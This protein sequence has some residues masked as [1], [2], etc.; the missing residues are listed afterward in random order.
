MGYTLTM[1]SN[2]DYKI[3]KGIYR[4]PTRRRS[5]AMP[6]L[7]SDLRIAQ[8]EDLKIQYLVQAEINKV[9]YPKNDHN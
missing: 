3:T 7:D 1:Y 8:G 5:S 6:K 9:R 2:E 4:K